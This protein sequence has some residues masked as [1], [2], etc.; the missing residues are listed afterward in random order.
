MLGSSIIEVW[1]KEGEKETKVV[2]SGDI[3]NN[4][5]PLLSEPTM[6]E[7]ADY[8]VM[9]STYGNRLHIR[10]DQKAQEFLRIVSETLSKGGTVVIPSFAV[11]RTQEILYELNNLKDTEHNEEFY[12]EY[13]TLMKA[14]VYVD[15]PL[16]I[17][18][19]EV[20]AENM[21]LFDEETQKLI[22]SGDNPL[23]F[24]GLKFTKTAEESKEL[25]ERNESSIIISASGMCEVGRIKHH[26]KHNL[27]NPKSTILFV[28]YQA[29]G[30]LGRKIVDGAKIVKIFGEDIAVNAR[31][32]YIEGYSGHA[33]QEWLLNF[34]YSFIRKPKHIFLVHGEPEGQV[35][36]RNKIIETTNIPVTIPDFGECYE[37]DDKINVVGK[38]EN[39]RAKEYVRLEVLGRMQTLKEELE[40]MESIVKEDILTEYANDEE[41][42]K[43]NDRIKELERQIV[44]IVENK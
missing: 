5:I 29:P 41:I 17:S 10:N 1:V 14:P 38:V 32:E 33:D 36:L 18:A 9:E 30:T 27:W 19:T 11:G 20:F 13:Q 22:K 21:D 16:A 15:S 28:G 37:L 12:K 24:P 43:L 8:L 35:V 3:G 44:K 42:A 31:I 23:E 25:N 4:D 2:F 26:L 6:I 7:S 34:V 39:K 40:D